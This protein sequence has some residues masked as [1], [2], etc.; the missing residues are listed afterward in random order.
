MNFIYVME[1]IIINNKKIYLKNNNKYSKNKNGRFIKLCKFENCVHVSRKET[2]YMYCLSHIDG[3]ELSK[4]DI[5]KRTVD[6]RKKNRNEFLEKNK[7]V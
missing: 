6:R 7:I 4:S 1:E 3:I 5:I 2:N